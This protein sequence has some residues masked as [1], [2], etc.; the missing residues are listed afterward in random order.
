LLLGVVAAQQQ[1][2]LDARGHGFDERVLGVN[3]ETAG[4]LGL[5]ME[6]A[7]AFELERWPQD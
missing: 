1:R 3:R 7:E 4:K 6:Y 2:N 5:A